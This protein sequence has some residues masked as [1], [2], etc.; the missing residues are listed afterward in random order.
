MAEPALKK[1][2][3]TYDEYRAIEDNTDVRHIFWDGEMFAMSGA[4]DAHNI[5]ESNVI[6]SLGIALRGRPC[7]ASTG[8]RR[9]RALGSDDAVYADATVMCGGTVTH[10]EDRNAATNPVVVVEVLSDST[11]KFDRGDKFAYYR[12]FPSIREVVLISQKQV[13]VERFTRTASGSWLLTEL[14][15]GAALALESVD[16]SIPVADLYEGTELAA[17]AISA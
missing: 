4:S 14:R 1:D 15:E 13:R 6:I 3:L 2:R 17:P 12:S 8:N 10:P 11:E 7:R 16:V 5:I 9:L